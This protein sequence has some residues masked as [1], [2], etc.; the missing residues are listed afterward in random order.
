MYCFQIAHF[1]VP[2]YIL[3][4]KEREFPLTIT[5]KVKKFEMRELSKV[6]LGLQQAV[7]HFNE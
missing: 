5:G 3:F 2:R 6:E 4:K 1:K 7:S